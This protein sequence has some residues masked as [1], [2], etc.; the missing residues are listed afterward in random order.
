MDIAN[1]SLDMFSLA[2]RSALVTG[3][4]TGLG[5]AFSLALAKAGA[6]VFA[7]GFGQRNGECPAQAG[8]AASDKSVAPGEGEHVEAEVGDVHRSA[9]VQSSERAH[10]ADVVGRNSE[11]GNRRW[12]GIVAAS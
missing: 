2:G 8:V 12:F 7:A 10:D 6:D 5:R 11:Q 3:G 4:N 9:T 1:F